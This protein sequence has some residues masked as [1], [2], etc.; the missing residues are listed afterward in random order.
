MST[1]APTIDWESEVTALAFFLSFGLN[2]SVCEVSSG[3]VLD[4]GQYFLSA[5]YLFAWF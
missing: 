3:V 2:D 4:V 1:S 5:S